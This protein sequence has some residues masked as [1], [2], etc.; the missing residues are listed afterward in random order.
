VRFCEFERVTILGLGSWTA[1]ANVPKSSSTEVVEVAGV[2][3]DTED[4]ILGV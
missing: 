2:C 4:V 1:D 3:L